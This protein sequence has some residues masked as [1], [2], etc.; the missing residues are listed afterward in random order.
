VRGEQPGD[1]ELIP[2]NF[3]ELFAKGSKPAAQ[4]DQYPAPSEIRAVFDRVHQQVLSELPTLAESD[5]DTKLDP[6]HRVF[7]T[8][9]GA[10]LWSA[11]TRC[12]IRVK[13]AC[14]GGCFNNSRC[15]SRRL[16]D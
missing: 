15:G 9:L 10:I 13:S 8:K 14:S 11:H 6:P 1:A 12:C 4:A 7:D 2:G 16:L 3:V 5:L